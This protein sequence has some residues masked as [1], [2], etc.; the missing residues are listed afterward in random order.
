MCFD[1][2]H[3]YSEVILFVLNVTVLVLSAG[4]IYLGIILRFFVS[5]LLLSGPF[6]S[7]SS[8]ALYNVLSTTEDYSFFSEFTRESGTWM[9]A[10]GLPLFCL[11]STGCFGTCCENREMLRYFMIAL[12][13]ILI[14]DFVVLGIGVAQLGAILS[15]KEQMKEELRTGY[16]L[17]PKG[18]NSISVFL[19][20]A[21]A[22]SEC[23]G[24]DGPGDFK[25][26]NMTVEHEGEQQEV[27]VPPI[28]CKH[29]A[30]DGGNAQTSV[31][32]KESSEKDV[33]NAASNDGPILDVISCAMDPFESGLLAKVKVLSIVVVVVGSTML[34]MLK[35]DVLEKNE[36][37]QDAA[38]VLRRLL[39]LV[40]ERYN[41]CLLTRDISIAL[42]VVGVLMFMVAACGCLGAC[43]E[44]KSMLTW[45][46]VIK[47]I[48]LVPEMAV[49]G[50]GIAGVTGMTSNVDMR[51]ALVKSLVEGYNPHGNNSFSHFLNTA[52]DMADC[53]GINGPEDFEDLQMTYLYEGATNNLKVPLICCNLSDDKTGPKAAAVN[54]DTIDLEKEGKE[55]VKTISDLIECAKSPEEYE[56]ESKLEAS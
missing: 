6:A 24:L 46:V 28:C 1:Y 26:R 36:Y 41:F 9:L 10:V 18:N 54:P 27:K 29:G 31:R 40:E 25:D 19:N 47:C 13:V 35:T 16:D 48:L 2:L 4:V 44:N 51:E 42:V 12:S 37:G 20:T 43:Q 32:D 50:V 23:C 5:G 55:A 21:M 15:L 8:H 17:S 45:F 30:K 7:D 34:V 38:T 22:M 49:V 11:S 3:D 39:T 56:L 53:C 14:A 33:Q 52:M